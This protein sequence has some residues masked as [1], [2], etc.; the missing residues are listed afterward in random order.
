[1]AKSAT[2]IIQDV[3]NSAVVDAIVALKAGAQGLP[4][5]L[6]RDLN[7]VHSNTAFDDLPEAVKK[8]H[9]TARRTQQTLV[10]PPGEKP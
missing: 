8:A 3:I 4:N 6:L 10:V 2:D 7:A 5:V 1:M 9:D